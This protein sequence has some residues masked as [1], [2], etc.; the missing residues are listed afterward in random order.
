[1]ALASWWAVSVTVIAFVAYRIVPS[2]L[3]LYVLL[4]ASIGF[5]ASAGVRD[6]LVMS[7]LA[8]FTWVIGRTIAVRPTRARLALG[9]AG[10]LAV[11][12]GFKY[13]P[14]AA[15][16]AN[17]LLRL[18]GSN[19]AVSVPHVTLPIGLSFVSFALIHFLVE[20]Y[21][22]AAV[23]DVA[24]FSLYTFFFPTV[25]LGPIKRYPDFIAD[26][27]AVEKQGAALPGSSD[28]GGGLWRILR[29][30][31]RKFVIADT[32]AMLVPYMTEP[33][34]SRAM[35]LVG[36]I[37]FSLQIYFDFAGYS[38]IAIG[39]ARLFGF[40]ILENFDR[41]Y[42][43]RNIS[44]FWKH[45]HISLTRFITEYVFIPLGGS[46]ASWWRVALNTM[47]AMGL[48]GLWHGAGWN[49]VVWG[50]YHGAGL[51]V[52]RWWQKGIRALRHRSPAFDRAL[53]ALPVSATGHVSAWVLTVSFVWL[54]WVLFALPID[55]A[56]AV[57]VK[58]L[59]L[60]AGTGTG[61]LRLLGGGV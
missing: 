29:G 21:R 44:D 40:H 22:G 49:F 6:M 41:P 47:I 4:L 30:L 39:I 17:V 13:L 27:Q 60:P 20:T 38:D 54:G 31:V 8:L 10:V 37:A 1:M 15:E 19:A 26:A 12:I 58:L 36:V 59:G 42:L 14:M 2:R 9:V 5:Y 53:G 16:T 57:Y 24:R 34:G 35:A 43:Q 61:L 46:R 3:R 52:L 33:G 32:V 11:L 56:V 48:S 50:L 45:W 23:P 25:T 7:G 55:S 18:A 51:V 28:V